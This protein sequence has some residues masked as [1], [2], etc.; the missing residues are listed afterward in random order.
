MPAVGVRP[1][2][3]LPVLLRGPA[4]GG[5]HPAV[6]DHRRQVDLGG[7]PVPV[8]DPGVEPEGGAVVGGERCVQR[9]QPVV[10]SDSGDGGIELI[11]R[12]LLRRKRQE[13]DDAADVSRFEGDQT[14]GRVPDVGLIV[15]TEQPGPFVFAN[16]GN[17]LR[18]AGNKQ[19][20]RHRAIWLPPVVEAASLRADAGSTGHNQDAEWSAI[21]RRG[22]DRS[23]GRCRARE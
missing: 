10:Q 2:P 17:D 9:E 15:L 19:L 23:P 18:R 14:C 12:H 8:D 3:V 1:E 16:A 13:I 7:V 4:R 6:L 22:R 5:P 20:P 11:E 21:G